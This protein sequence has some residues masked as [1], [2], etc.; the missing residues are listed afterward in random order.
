[1]I[2]LT[3][4]AA[5]RLREMRSDADGEMLRVSSCCAGLRYVLEFVDTT[6][7]GDLV[8]ESQG[9]LVV[10]DEA[11]AELF[12][13]AEFDYDDARAAFSVRG[14]RL[15]SGQC[16]CGSFRDEA[17]GERRDSGAPRPARPVRGGRRDRGG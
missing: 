12:G 5:E 2:S 17:S 1:M 10:V 11:S 16:A 7:P 9:T 8:S 13:D 15:V 4:R 6:Q 3:Q 14:P